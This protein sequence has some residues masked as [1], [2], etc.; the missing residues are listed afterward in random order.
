MRTEVVAGQYLDLEASR[1]PAPPEP[2][3]RRI[4]RLKSG[5]YTV[6]KPLLIG[7]AL[8]GAPPEF[9]SALSAYGLALGE[10]F[11]IRDD[12]LGV[13]GD[14]EVTG[15][16]AEGDL[17][18]G[19]RTLLITRALAAAPPADRA[20]ME[21]TL[22]RGELDAAEAERVRDIIRSTGAYSSTLTA[23]DDLRSR[24]I[25]ALHGSGLP[26]EVLGELALLAD[27]AIV[28]ES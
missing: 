19:K 27:Q 16:D 28:R 17:R 26:Q 21:A 11:Q 22:G 13:F 25:E 4:A 5:A 15:K 2:A 23:M 14:P 3:V 10:A 24:A 1:G 12:V 20:Y 18:E 9:E 8:S 6:E 7:A